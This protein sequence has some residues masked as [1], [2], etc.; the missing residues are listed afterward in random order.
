MSRII[1]DATGETMYPVGHDDGI[2]SGS[3]VMIREITK[4]LA[5]A[6]HTVHVVCNDLKSEEQRD[7]RLWYW[8]P[9][10][11]PT[12]ANVVVMTHQIDPNTEYETDKLVLAHTGCTPNLGPDGCWALAVDA[13]PV[14]SECHKKLLLDNNPTIISRKVF[15]TGLGVNLDD[16][17]LFWSDVGT[18]DWATRVGVRKVPGRMLYANDPARGL[19]NV[20]D[21]FDLVK[22]EVPDATLHIAYDFD[23]NL[24]RHRWEHTQM[25]QMLLECKRRIENTPGVVSLGALSREQ[26]IREQLECQVHCMPSD[27]PNAGT[28]TH[29]LLQLECAAAGAALVL[30]DVEAFPEVFGEAATIIP[31]IGKFMPA[32]E[33]RIT[34]SDYAGEVVMLMTRPEY[35]RPRSLAARALAES[36]SWEKVAEEWSS[37]LATILEKEKVSA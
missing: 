15:V 19:W 5:E 26:I 33:R 31:V 12:D 17:P 23:G 8:G 4:R 7:E 10:N 20:L 9:K 16:Y 24:E 30:S 14:F 21:I 28:Q 36:M 18:N 37:M 11:H 13:W 22:K 25:A 27:P 32:L 1:W 2:T 34:A 35:W 6:G 29:G 3:V